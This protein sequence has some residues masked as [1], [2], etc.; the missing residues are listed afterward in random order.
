ML[1][2]P[3]YIYICIHMYIQL[4]YI[5]IFNWYIYIYSIDIYIIYIYVPYNITRSGYL[6]YRI[7]FCRHTTWNR[8]LKA[9]MQHRHCIYRVKTR[10]SNLPFGK[11]T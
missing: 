8:K 3:I 4:I 6:D 5:Y 2:S 11:Q 10:M 7:D 1:V 9:Y